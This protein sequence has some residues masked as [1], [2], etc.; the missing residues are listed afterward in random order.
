MTGSPDTGSAVR[1]PRAP[2]SRAGVPPVM[3]PA[4]PAAR[5]GR[6]PLGGPAPFLDDGL[7]EWA[8]PDDRPAG[9]G[10]WWPAEDFEEPWPDYAA[11]TPVDA[12][13]AAGLD[14][15][16]DAGFLPRDAVPGQQ[17][18]AGSGFT[19]GHA[20]DTSLPGPALAQALDAAAAGGYSKLDDDELIGVLAGW[21]KTEAWAAAG[22]LAAIAELA[23][24]RPPA[25]RK[26]A[27]TRGGKPAG[28]DKFCA[29]E[30]AVALALSRRSAE[31]MVPL[32]HDL[33]TRLPLTRQALAEGVIGDYKAQLIAEATRVLGDAAAAEAEAAVVPE[34]VTGKTPAQIRAAIGR[35]VLKAD[36]DAAR[37]RREEAEKDPRVE[38]WREDAGTAA[39][40]GYGLPADA[41]LA[42]D[43][44]I[45]TAA[46]ELKAAGLAGTM[47]QLRARA[48]L[49]ALLGKDSRPTPASTDTPSPETVDAEAASPEPASTEPASPEPASPEPASPDAASAET[50]GA[51][52][53]SPETTG[54]G[55]GSPA[56]GIGSAQRDPAASDADPD[57][58]APPEQ[59]NDPAGPTGPAGHGTPGSGN[60][61]D[62]GNDPAGAPDEAPGNGPGGPDGPDG[63]GGASGPAARPAGP[64]K[65]TARAGTGP[66]PA[67]AINLTI[68]LTTLLGLTGHPGEAAAFGPIDATLARTMAA[69]AAGNPATTWCITVTDEHGHPTAH[70]CAK[71]G[72]RGKPR[73]TKDL[74][75][76]PPGGRTSPPGEDTTPASTKTSPPGTGSGPPGE[77]GTWRLRLPGRSLDLTAA[78]EPLAVTECDHRHQ[79]SAHDPG[80]TLRHLVEIR[81]GE[82]TYPPC[83]REAR[84][85][86]FEHAIPWDQGGRTCSCN[87]GPRCRHHHH[88]KQAAGWTLQ[89]NQP[90]YHTWTTPAGRRYTTGPITYP[91]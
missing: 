42:A 24:R 48:Y 34:G 43:Q 15:G 77:Y 40:C 14:P 27:A 83:L 32:A 47:D 79:T 66:P 60:G 71:P 57:W 51:E 1:M 31:R 36:P 82:C 26:E 84:R 33:A 61:P 30:T 58:A 18:R 29:D 46:L 86:D 70:G 65:A 23:A 74:G 17:G 6:R 12:G 53:A 56:P 5:A 25:T 4:V 87:T 49:D 88:L 76:S 90:G 45:T 38:L 89:Q 8:L 7:P 78:L 54:S 11:M 16:L 50:T 73:H 19:S 21:A 52:P 22:R 72:R 63:P 13:P 3:A 80:R 81:D 10:D 67:A 69:H 39:I 62:G 75:G 91:I 44:A 28:W 85:C 37:R 9:G 64:G 68:P 41:A 35:A 59:G 2:V 20:F 55:V